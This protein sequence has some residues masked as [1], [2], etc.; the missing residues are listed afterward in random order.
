MIFVIRCLHQFVSALIKQLLAVFWIIVK[1][2]DF[3]VSK[4]PDLAVDDC[5]DI[6][7]SV[8]SQSVVDMPT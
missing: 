1:D 7:Q 6:L 4:I 3:S 8:P 2:N 5:V